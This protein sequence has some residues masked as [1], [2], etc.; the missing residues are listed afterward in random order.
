MN[1][2]IDKQHLPVFNEQSLSSKALLNGA[3]TT[4]NKNR[5]PLTQPYAFFF[6]IKVHCLCTA[7]CC[8][9]LHER[10]QVMKHSSIFFLLTHE[11]FEFC[12]TATFPITTIA[13]HLHVILTSL[14]L[15]L[16][17]FLYTPLFVRISFCS[18]VLVFSSYCLM[19]LSAMKLFFY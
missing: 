17:S 3:V 5:V 19:T 12:V 15:L 14:I 8:I 4:L 6:Y 16:S 2:M 10:V 18:C 7:I 9:C 1:A 13:K 11:W